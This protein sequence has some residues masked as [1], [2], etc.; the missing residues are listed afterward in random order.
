MNNQQDSASRYSPFVPDEPESQLFARI[1]IG[2]PPVLILLGFVAFWVYLSFFATSLINF[3]AQGDPNDMPSA[4]HSIGN[5]LQFGMIYNLLLFPGV[6]SLVKIY[7]P[8]FAVKN[9]FAWAL[10]I[11]SVFVFFAFFKEILWFFD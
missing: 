4:L 1:A 7:K 9:S 3:G 10:W 8:A 11:C 5:F 6:H 2:Y